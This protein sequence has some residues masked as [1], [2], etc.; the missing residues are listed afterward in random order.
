MPVDKN[1]SLT[2]ARGVALDVHTVVEDW[3]A[4]DMD[5]LV[6]YSSQLHV[7]T[8]MHIRIKRWKAVVWVSRMMSLVLVLRA[9]MLASILGTRTTQVWGSVIWLACYSLMQV[10]SFLISAKNPDLLLEGQ[11]A[12]VTPLPSINF[13]GRKAA[14]IFIAAYHSLRSYLRA[15]VTTLHIV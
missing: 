13:I 15:A 2:A 6:E 10:P 1:A 4:S 14:L 8:N 12:K 9:S 11:P 5:V 3:N 7:L